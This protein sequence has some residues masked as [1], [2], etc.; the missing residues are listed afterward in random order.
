MFSSSWI[1]HKTF[2]YYFTFYF[3]VQ[4]VSCSVNI[5]LNKRC[6]FT[7]FPI[8]N[9]FLNCRLAIKAPQILHYRFIQIVATTVD[10]TAPFWV[11]I[12]ISVDINP[13]KKQTHNTLIE[14]SLHYWIFTPVARSSH[15]PSTLQLTLRH[16]SPLFRLG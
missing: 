13:R 3:F 6:T 16:Y 5:I 10:S 9:S 7:I 1:T 14:L 2:F 8:S 12:F 4:I 11:R 15:H